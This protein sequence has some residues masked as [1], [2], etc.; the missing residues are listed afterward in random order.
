MSYIGICFFTKEMPSE[1]DLAHFPKCKSD[2]AIVIKYNRDK[3]KMFFETH[4]TNP[5]HPCF[6]DVIYDE[7]PTKLEQYDGWSFLVDED[8]TGCKQYKTIY[9]ILHEHPREL[10]KLIFMLYTRINNRFEKQNEE[11][12]IIAGRN[13]PKH[14]D[15]TTGYQI[16]IPMNLIDTIYVYPQVKD[17]YKEN[18]YEIPFMSNKI[19]VNP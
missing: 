10:D 13:I 8:E 14:N 11:R 2:N 16:P 17:K 19:K 7:V 3:L 4:R 9:G 5:L 12:I 15:N 18:L 6:H 1:H